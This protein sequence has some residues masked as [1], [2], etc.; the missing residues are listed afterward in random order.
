MRKKRTNTQKGMEQRRKQHVGRAR[1]RKWHGRERK[2]G[3]GRREKERKEERG[4][5]RKS[6]EE[7]KMRSA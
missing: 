4:E 2:Q 7:R 1:V 5:K 3:E 6:R